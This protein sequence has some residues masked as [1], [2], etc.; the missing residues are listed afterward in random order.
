MATSALGLRCFI[1]NTCFV[2]CYEMAQN[3]T[4]LRFINAKQLC[5]FLCRVDFFQGFCCSDLIYAPGTIGVTLAC[6][7][8]CFSS[9]KPENSKTHGRIDEHFYHR[10]QFKRDVAILVTFTKGLFLLLLFQPHQGA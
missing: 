6:E 4:G 3:S 5:V 10:H 7:Q 8:F 1:V 2:Y 9:Q